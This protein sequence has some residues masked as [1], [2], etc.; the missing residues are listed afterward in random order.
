MPG[1]P[2]T[3]PNVRQS[4]ARALILRVDRLT[5]RANLA[6]IAPTCVDEPTAGS[7]AEPMIQL[8]DLQFGYREGDFPGA[9]A[10]ARDT[11]AL[12]IYPELPH[13]AVEKVADAI[14]HVVGER[15]G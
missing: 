15:R 12:P 10:A 2:R 14:R 6:A 3:P 11:L 13:T 5:S 8:A 7:F 4:R 9:E 1:L